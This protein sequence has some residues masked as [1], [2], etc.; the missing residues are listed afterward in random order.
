MNRKELKTHIKKLEENFIKQREILY[1]LYAHKNNPYIIGDI[2]TDHMGS[3][4][5]KR[6]I[7]IHVDPNGLPENKYYGIII[8]D[9]KV[10]KYR[11][12]YQSMIVENKIRNIMKTVFSHYQQNNEMDN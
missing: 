3:I 1:Q 12:I 9:N 6:I 4:K 7:G 10:V 11:V 2:I 8:D 5:Y